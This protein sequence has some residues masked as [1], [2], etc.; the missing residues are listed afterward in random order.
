[1][2]NTRL[3]NAVLLVLG[4]AIA[5]LLGLAPFELFRALW[6]NNDLKARNAL[7]N[8]TPSGEGA[9]GSRF[10]PHIRV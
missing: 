8:E 2:A 1:M 7:L 10:S 4:A 6:G 5:S 3:V 9:R